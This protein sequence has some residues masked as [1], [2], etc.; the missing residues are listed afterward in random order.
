[1]FLRKLRI[2]DKFKDVSIE[3]L[4]CEVID[5]DKKKIYF[6]YIDEKSK[7]FFGYYKDGVYYPTLKNKFHIWKNDKDYIKAKRNIL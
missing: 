1:M 3:N 4:I 6:K 5:I 2:G 7:S